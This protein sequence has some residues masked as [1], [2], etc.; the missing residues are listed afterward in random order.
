MRFF[1]E[2]DKLLLEDELQRIELKGDV[3]VDEYV[4]GTSRGVRWAVRLWDPGMWVKTSRG[5]A[6][7]GGAG[8][9][10]TFPFQNFE[11]KL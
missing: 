7:G 11:H 9:W 6:V 5:S 3:N 10:G 4:T 8:G 2:T 1:D